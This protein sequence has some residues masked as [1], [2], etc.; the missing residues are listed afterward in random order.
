MTS[1][2]RPPRAPPLTSVPSTPGPEL[3]GGYPRNST[4]FTT[5]QWDH[6]AQK[7]QKGESSLFS[8]AKTYLSAPKAYLPPA[9]A[10]Y[11]PA[12]VD[13]ASLKPSSASSPPGSP[14]H[15]PRR[16]AAHRWQHRERFQHTCARGQGLIARHIGDT[17]TNSVTRKPS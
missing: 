3:P 16:C 6:S 17:N 5:N 13:P 9:V 4:V 1:T 7:A 15:T 11:F 12:H 14:G 10:S 8:T 2:A